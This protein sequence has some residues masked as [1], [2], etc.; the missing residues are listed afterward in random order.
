M[1]PV[2]YRHPEMDFEAVLETINFKQIGRQEIL[3]N[4]PVLVKKYNEIRISKNNDAGKRW[5]MGNLSKIAMGNISLSEL[6]RH[7]IIDNG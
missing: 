5:I 4:I 6:S 2:I 7:I 3:D 1:L